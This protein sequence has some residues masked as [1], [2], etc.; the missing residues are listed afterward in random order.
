MNVT[1]LLE[2]V[3]FVGM[4]LA[5]ISGERSGGLAELQEFAECLRGTRRL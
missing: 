4:Q 5:R 2:D 1:Q 3:V